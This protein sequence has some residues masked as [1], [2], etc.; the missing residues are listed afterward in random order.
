LSHS[1][2]YVVIL[3]PNFIVF[4]IQIVSSK[5]KHFRYF[6]YDKSSP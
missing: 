2:F 5:R 1:N 3:S 4:T 6:F